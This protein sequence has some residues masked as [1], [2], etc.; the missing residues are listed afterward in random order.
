MLQQ[1]EPMTKQNVFFDVAKYISQ[2]GKQYTKCLIVLL[3][4]IL[5]SQTAF[6]QVK[7]PFQV[8]YEADIRGELTFIANNIVNRYEAERTV[9]GW[10]YRDGRWRYETYTIPGN[11]SNDPYNDT[12]NSSSSNDS[13]DMQ[14][15]DVDN[16]NTTFSSSSATLNIPDYNCA[17]VRYAGL[18]WSA[19]YTDSDR[20]NIDEIK[21]KLPGGV[22]QD[23]T[24]DEI[25]YD[26][27]GDADFGYYSPYA[28]YKDITSL[29]TGLG[30]PNGD[31][32][33]ANVRASVGANIS[34][35]VSGGWKMVIVYE[36]PTLPGDKFI[37]TFDGY[38]GIKS[39]ESVDI[40]ISGFTTLPAPFPV[41]ASMGVA[42]LEGD[43]RI[44]GDELEINANGSFTTLSNG[45]NPA[46]NFFNSSITIDDAQF[47]TRNPN[48]V[49]TLGWDV[50]YFEIPNGG[51]N[52]TVIPNGATS[53]I[54][55]ASSSQDKYDIFF[56]SFDVDIIAPNITLEKRVQTPGGVDITGQGVNLGQTLDYVLTFENIGND[57][58]IDYTIRDVLPVNVSPPDGRSFFNASDFSLPDGVTYVYDPL[59]REIIFTVPDRYVEDEDS[60]YSIRFR[61]QVAEN[62]Y[63]FINA[64]SDLIKNQP[65]YTI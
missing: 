63:D 58:G 14:Y 12:G 61:V 49:N 3:F 38:A 13:F 15:I 50:D 18:Y 10:R 4:I 51:V 26:G 40:P 11:S 7:R 25:I 54:L 28:A 55:R 43:N 30:N 5:G 1:I 8:R 44:E 17:L 16:D 19:V 42:A 31:Y 62:C 35:G 34:G 6:S 41:Y 23:I 52:N 21:F 53:A 57:D 46:N 22:Y 60:S 29:I 59:T 45:Q 20:S 33:V 47:T 56:T 64:C 39:G 48:S 32:F 24:A 36:D 37:T 27:Y 9:R 65:L 2:M